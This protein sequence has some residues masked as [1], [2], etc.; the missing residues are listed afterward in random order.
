MDV[1]RQYRRRD[2][3]AL[4]NPA[5]DLHARQ[6]VHMPCCAIWKTQSSVKNSGSQCTISFRKQVQFINLFILTAPWAPWR[7][8]RHV[9]RLSFSAHWSH[10]RL[11][12]VSTRSFFYTRLQGFKNCMCSPVSQQLLVY[13]LFQCQNHVAWLETW[14]WSCL[15]MLQRGNRAV[16]PV[17]IHLCI[18]LHKTQSDIQASCKK[19][20]CILCVVNAVA[21][22]ISCKFLLADFPMRSIT[23]A[24]LTTQTE[25]VFTGWEFALRSKKPLW[26][27]D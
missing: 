3:A 2:R 14:K 22:P 13:P 24:V 23:S 7:G 10:C 25:P 8:S 11:I 1:I 27:T 9:H 16:Q 5:Q 4:A 19:W 17:H 26:Q 12:T 6:S 21:F 18:H 15:L 20:K